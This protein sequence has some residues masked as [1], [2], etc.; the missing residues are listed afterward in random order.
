[1]GICN[2]E[3]VFTATVGS[4]AIH[5][6]LIH[7]HTHNSFTLPYLFLTIFYFSNF[8]SISCTC[9]SF[10]YLFIFLLYNIHLFPSPLDF[11]QLSKFYIFSHTGHACR[12]VELSREI[13]AIQYWVRGV[14]A[15]VG[16]LVLTPTKAEFDLLYNTHNK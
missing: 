8:P 15:R 6:F 3:G 7:Q 11:Y 5:K 13:V 12:A 9:L 2:V 10:I 4:F 1:M 16:K 14:E